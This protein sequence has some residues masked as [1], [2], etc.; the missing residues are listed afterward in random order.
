MLLFIPSIR[1]AP[2]SPLNSALQGNETKGGLLNPETCTLVQ[3][4]ENRQTR[5]YGG[6]NKEKAAPYWVASWAVRPQHTTTFASRKHTRA[7]MFCTG[8]SIS[9]NMYL[10]A[11]KHL[12]EHTMY[13]FAVSLAIGKRTQDALNKR[14]EQYSHHNLRL[15]LPFRS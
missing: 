13:P 7:K 14:N 3:A 10:T 1:T 2:E 12:R 4:G 6:Y 11:R 9:Y 8:K 5:K 15:R